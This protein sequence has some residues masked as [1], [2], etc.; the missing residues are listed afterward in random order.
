MNCLILAGGKGTRLKKVLPDTPKILAPVKNKSFLFYKLR[1]LISYGIKDITLLLKYQAN[2]I[3]D[4]IENEKLF[5][6]HNIDWVIESKYLDTGGSIAHAVNK[7]GIKGDF[8]VMNGDTW[9]DF[10]YRGFINKNSPCIAIKYL[11]NLSRFG[12]VEI[13]DSKIIRFVEKLHNINDGWINAGIYKFNHSLF[14]GWDGK[15]FSLEK[16][17]LNKLSENKKLTYFKVNGTFIDIGIPQD[18][19]YFKKFVNKKNEFK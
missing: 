19:E 2:Q 4:E 18:Y 17:M 13:N 12:F 8:I 10:D 14:K 11:D 9:L 6:D 15:P 16:K 1:Q 3:I 5:K 7:K